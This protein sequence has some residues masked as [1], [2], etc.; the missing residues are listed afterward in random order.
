MISQASRP[1]D[2]RDERPNSWYSH[3]ICF[4]GNDILDD[5]HEEAELQSVSH[6]QAFMLSEAG[7]APSQFKWCAW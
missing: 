1:V 4:S 7:F 3:F 6:E 5:L 2:H